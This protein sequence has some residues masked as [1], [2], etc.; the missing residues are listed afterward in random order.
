MDIWR[1]EHKNTNIGPFFSEEWMGDVLNCYYESNNYRTHPQPS[2]RAS[3]IPYCMYCGCE[4]FEAIFHWFDFDNVLAKL[5]KAGFVLRKFS[6][7]EVFYKDEFQVMF[8]R[9]DAE[10]I[11]EI[12]L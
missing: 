2:I 6:I 12:M 10:L 1:I 11:E 9:Y 5:G 7:A 4:T 3:N 8:D